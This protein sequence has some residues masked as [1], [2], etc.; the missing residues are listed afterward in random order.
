MKFRKWSIS[1]AILASL[2][3]MTAVGTKV[4]A[5]TGK[6]DGSTLGGIPIEGLKDDEA[7]SL[8]QSEIKS[9][10]DGGTLK[11]K[12][13]YE[14]YGIPRSAFK[15]HI[16]AS[17]TDFHEQTKRS[18][19]TFFLKPDR[20]D[21]P[22]VVTVNKKEIELPERMEA[23][24]TLKRAKDAAAMLQERE[25]SI[26][27]VDNPEQLLTPVASISYKLPSGLNT[28]GVAQIVEG[29]NE[30]TITPD[31]K[32]SFLKVVKVPAELKER[33]EE[34]NLLATGLFEMALN[35]DMKIAE[36]HSQSELPDYAKPG[37]EAAVNKKTDEDLLLLN[38]D[39]RAYKIQADMYGD[40]LEMSLLA[41]PGEESY[42]YELMDQ[43]PISSRIVYR[44]NASLPAG[45]EQVEEQ[46]EDG[47]QVD[48]YRVH[49]AKD[50]AMI[51]KKLIRRAAYLPKPQIVLTSSQEV[52]AE[53]VPDINQG[54]VGPD[55]SLIP[56]PNYGVTPGTGTNGGIT[57]PDTTIPGNGSV[58]QPDIGTTPGTTTPGTTAPTVPTTPNTST[59]ATPGTSN[60]AV[61]GGTNTNLPPQISQATPE[62]KKDLYDSLRDDCIR[63]EGNKDA[64]NQQCTNESEILSNWLLKFL[65]QN[66]VWN[67]QEQ[68]APITKSPELNG[69]LKGMK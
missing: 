36:H 47:M 55:G 49:K 28:A 52:E 58:T 2:L 26:V 37:T 22:L 50:G 64:A 17:L 7:K 41:I 13:K 45:S 24:Q 3:C 20:T 57:T 54:I 25:P 31:S 42:A 16:D 59:P 12:S 33:P 63:E 32:F 11:L 14:S 10:M 23:K 61:N 51:D 56:D 46:G 6:A 65:T 40:T 62:M 34:L 35:T 30:K 18:W 27:Y 19:S 8:I 29:L 60:G 4:S 66:G 38:G 39:G 1:I 15:F 21:V 44:Y 5:A 43:Q 53:P 48:V 68:S 67:N 69:I 9:W